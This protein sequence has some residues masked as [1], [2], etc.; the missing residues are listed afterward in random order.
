MLLLPTT[1]P[2]F[3]QM[4]VYEAGFHDPIPACMQAA[5]SVETAMFYFQANALGFLPECTRGFAQRD[6][7]QGSLTCVQAT[8]STETAMIRF[9]TNALGFT[10]APQGFLAQGIYHERVPDTCTQATSSVE[11]AMFYF[12]TNE[13]GVMP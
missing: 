10:P 8:P 12:Q 3:C 2:L 1:S 7:A 13:L 5:P 4:G 6:I 9:Q 11:T